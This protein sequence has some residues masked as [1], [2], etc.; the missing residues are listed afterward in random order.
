M[1]ELNEAQKVVIAGIVSGAIILHGLDES[2][3]HIWTGKIKD[4]HTH[5]EPY[6]A[7]IF[8]TSNSIAATMSTDT[9]WVK[10]DAILTSGDDE[11]ED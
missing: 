5:R 10:L 4:P 1:F 8:R 3:K 11:K 2:G 9:S 7:K 6:K